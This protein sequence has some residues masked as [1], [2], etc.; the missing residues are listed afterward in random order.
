MTSVNNILGARMRRLVANERRMNVDG[1]VLPREISD[2][3]KHQLR[4]FLTI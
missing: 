2:Q 3:D 4:L 1:M